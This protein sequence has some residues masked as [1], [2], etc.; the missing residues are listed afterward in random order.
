MHV[1]CVVA[2]HDQ[3]KLKLPS[4]QGWCYKFSAAVYNREHESMHK[5]CQAAESTSESLAEQSLHCLFLLWVTVS[6]YGTHM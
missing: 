1:Q 4:I 6:I 2:Y 3:S 5:S